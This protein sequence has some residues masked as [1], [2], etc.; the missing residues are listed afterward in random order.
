MTKITNATKTSSSENPRAR[1][2]IMLLGNIDAPGKPIDVDVVLALARRDGDASA[3][4]APVGIEADRADPVG[5][6]FLLRSEK[7][8]IGLGREGIFSRVPAHAKAVLI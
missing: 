4:R 5:D 6:D 2:T 8:E 7:L 1:C 3:G